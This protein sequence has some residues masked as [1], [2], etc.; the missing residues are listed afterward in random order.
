M[1]ACQRNGPAFGDFT[2]I[3]TWSK[4]FFPCV[5]TVELI[6]Q[7][8]DTGLSK[9]TYYIPCYDNQ[10]DWDSAS[11]YCEDRMMNLAT[12]D[13]SDEANYFESVAASDV[14]VG[15]RDFDENNQFSLV[16]DGKNIES[17]LPWRF[18]Q[19]DNVGERCVVILVQEDFEGFNDVDCYREFS[20]SCESVQKS[21]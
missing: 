10:M 11:K 4:L 2:E 12:F 18:G 13:S 14:W 17:F 15:I 7:F 9:K 1:K 16:T 3:G 21:N 5:I 20:F 8:T 19:P 6:F